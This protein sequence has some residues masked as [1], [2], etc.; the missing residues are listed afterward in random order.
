[1]RALKTCLRF[2]KNLRLGLGLNK[3]LIPRGLF[4]AK[5]IKILILFITGKTVVG[6][7]FWSR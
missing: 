4:K 6:D 3:G 5:P 7:S 2:C 1:M